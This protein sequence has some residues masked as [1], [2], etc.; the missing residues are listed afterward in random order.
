[1]S[2]LTPMRQAE[3]D[4]PAGIHDHD[5]PL[6]DYGLLDG[7]SAGNRLRATIPDIDEV[8]SSPTARTCRHDRR[9][10]AAGVPASPHRRAPRQTVG[11]RGR[12]RLGQVGTRPVRGIS[13]ATSC[14]KW[15]ALLYLFKPFSSSATKRAEPGDGTRGPR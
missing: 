4:R 1:M 8:L 7:A 12:A 2:T 11:G 6:S 10:A 13:G 9:W 14:A 5:R 3:S 15:S